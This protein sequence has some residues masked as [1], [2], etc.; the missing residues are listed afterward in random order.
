MTKGKEEP[1]PGGSVGWNIVPTS[2]GCRFNPWHR[3][4][5]E[6]TDSYFSL[7]FMFLPLSL[8]L[9]LLNISSDENF[10]KKRGGAVVPYHSPLLRC[11]LVDGFLFLGFYILDPGGVTINNQMKFLFQ[12][13]NTTC[14]R[15]EKT[16]A[17]KGGYT[18]LALPLGWPLW[19]NENR[20]QQ[21]LSLLANEP[22][23]V[24]CHHQAP[25]G[26]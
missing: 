22:S 4:L 11:T 5:R 8:P 19:Y 15:L 12:N 10:F 9:S 20:H 6:A 25:V 14:Q 17:E 3:H 2:K 26:K 13:I 1:W 16:H 18:H 23:A 7:T 24:S 21:S